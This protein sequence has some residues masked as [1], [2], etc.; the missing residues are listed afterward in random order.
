MGVRGGLPT[1]RDNSVM[2]DLETSSQLDF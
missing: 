2:T 1:K